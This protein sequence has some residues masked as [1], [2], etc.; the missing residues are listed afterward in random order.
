M[1]S[2]LKGNSPINT[3]IPFLQKI[4]F[5][6]NRAENGDDNNSLEEHLQSSKTRSSYLDVKLCILVKIFKFCLVTK[7][8]L[9]AVFHSASILQ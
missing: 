9:N 5:H 2:D 1:Y 8:L 6:P 4:F 3:K 7:T